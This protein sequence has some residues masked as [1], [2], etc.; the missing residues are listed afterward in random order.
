M[1]KDGEST[2]GT[3][4]DEAVGKSWLAGGTHENEYEKPWR[5]AAAVASLECPPEP[6]VLD[7]A[8]GPGGFLAAAL[9]VIPG[10]VGIWLDSL[11]TM[12]AQAR[13]QLKG[14][15]DRVAFRR[16][17]LLDLGAAAEPDSVRLVSVSRATHHLDS[18]QLAEFYKQA[19]QVIQEGGWLANLDQAVLPEPWASR[20]ASARRRAS[21]EP[22]A[23]RDP[24]HP[25]A[26][27]HSLEEHIDLASS[28][29]FVELTPVWRYCQHVLLMGRKP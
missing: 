5:L 18:D 13:S 7:V 26:L 9:E 6:L 14:F 11:E 16:G 8:S 3:G 2:R 1:A 24:G 22:R 15:G 10:S 19:A 27:P 28:A 20:L 29:G 21:S 23:P 25:P 17:D 12:E 4:W